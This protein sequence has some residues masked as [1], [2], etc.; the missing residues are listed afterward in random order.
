MTRT[1]FS[2][3]EV[4]ATD[5]A[6]PHSF[7]LELVNQPVDFDLNRVILPVR[8]AGGAWSSVRDYARYVQMEIANGMLPDGTRYVDEDALLARR[9]IQVRVG[10][11]AWYGMGLFL[12]D[13]KGIRVVSHGGSMIGYK[14]NF[15]FVPE[16]GLGGV[17]LTNADTGY[18]VANAFTERVL[19][20]VYDGEPEAEEDL[21]SSMNTTYESNRGEQKDW[22]VPPEPEP[23]GRLAGTYRSPVLGDVIVSRSGPD[24]TFRFGGWK[25][26]VATK[27]NPDGTIS[28]VTVDPGTRGFE[29]AARETDGSYFSLTLRDLQHEYPF[30]AVE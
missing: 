25:S 20:I 7:D 26:R 6:M 1:T 4:L 12:E 3:E 14:S 29:F 19:E 30:D 15:F 28:F 17:I 9:E 18:S 21:A 11:E 22:V 8:P 5:H 10:E 24:V 2:F 27:R 23:V 13:I 16:T